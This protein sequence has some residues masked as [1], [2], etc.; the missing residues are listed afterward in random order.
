MPADPSPELRNS[1]DRRYVLFAGLAL[2][3]AGAAFGYYQWASPVYE[4][5]HLS[6]T[7]AHQLA[8]EGSVLLIDIRQPEEWRQ[9]GIPEGAEELD[10]RRADFADAL[11]A[12]LGTDQTRPIALICARGVR[13]A[14]LSNA[15]TKAGFDNI[16]DVPE[17][18]LGSSAGPG[19]LASGLPT[20]TYSEPSG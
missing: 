20:R 18:M 8:K 11:H 2:L 3:G 9:T 10:M 12:M 6:V 16:I 4:G 7:Q 15:L 1:F 19:W 13:S 17:G 5:G 14:R